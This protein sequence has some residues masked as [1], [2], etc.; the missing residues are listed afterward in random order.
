[1]AQGVT[2]RWLSNK[3]LWKEHHQALLDPMCDTTPPRNLEPGNPS[4]YR[5]NP[6]STPSEGLST[7]P[8]SHHAAQQSPSQSQDSCRHQDT[9]QGL[10]GEKDDEDATT[11]L[12]DNFVAS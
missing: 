5:R 11:A 9:F 8:Q 12:Q 3:Q 1:M 2:C 4:A 6:D 7:P 10:K